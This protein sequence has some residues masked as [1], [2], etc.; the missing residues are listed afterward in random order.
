M[1]SKFLTVDFLLDWC[2]GMKH[3]QRMYKFLKLY[4]TILLFIEQIKN[5]PKHQI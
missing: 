5:L 3:T 1:V 4:N 2:I